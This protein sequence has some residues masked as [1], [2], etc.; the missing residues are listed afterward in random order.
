MKA[1]FRLYGELNDYLPLSKQK[2]LFVAECDNQRSVKSVIDSIGVPLS[3]VDLILANGEP[4]GFDYLLQANDRIA[5]YPAFH[6]IDISP[7]HL[8]NQKQTH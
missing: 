5:I 3:K 2:K 1:G 8:I 7:L 6:S 4:A